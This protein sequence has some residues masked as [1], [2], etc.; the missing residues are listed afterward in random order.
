MIKINLLPVRAA[1]RRESLR[2]QMLIIV[3]SLVFVLACLYLVDRFQHREMS[4]LVSEINY[5]KTEMA[6]LK[7]IIA[8]VEML[9]ARKKS[10]QEKKAVIDRLEAA[11]TGPVRVLEELGFAVPEA[12]W[13]ISFKEKNGLLELK[14]EAV[15]NDAIADFLTNMEK[16]IYFKDVRLRETTTFVDK[17]KK[18]SL[19]KFV[20]TAKVQ[21]EAGA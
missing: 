8:E 11:K 14:G 15:N 10:L 17:K 1:K 19:K 5:T 2:R 18:A 12:L 7:D 9:K 3:A 4:R 21:Y 6:K 16:S 20:I 13:V